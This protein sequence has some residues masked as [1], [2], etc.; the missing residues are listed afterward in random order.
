[1]LNGAFHSWCLSINKVG[2]TLAAKNRRQVREKSERS[3]FAG[4]FRQSLF[5][6]LNSRGAREKEALSSR[7]KSATRSSE[8]RMGEATIC[9]SAYLA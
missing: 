6:A 5:V 1:L 2:G 9:A 7:G 3:Q 4:D 8:L